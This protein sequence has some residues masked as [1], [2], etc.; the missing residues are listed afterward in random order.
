MQLPFP[1]K[2]LHG[3]GLRRSQFTRP[4]VRSVARTLCRKGVIPLDLLI[5]APLETTFRVTVQGVSFLY[6]LHFDDLFGSK[7]FWSGASGFEPDTVP[8]FIEH[9]KTAPRIIDVGA[10]TGFYTLLASAVNPTCKVMC[11]EPFAPTFQR[12]QQNIRRNKVE[13]R[14]RAV[15]AAVSNRE[16]EAELHGPDDKS[17]CALEEREGTIRVSALSLDS[18]VPMDGN[19]KLVKIDVEGHEH[20]VL[21]GMTGVVSDSRPAIFFECNP[22]G[23][24]AFIESF[25]RDHRYRMFSLLDRNVRELS[26]LVP[27]EMPHGHHNFL[28]LACEV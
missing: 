9:A 26:K 14:C 10:H 5:G 18:V 17:M 27:E 15:E 25:L 13:G 1:F 19:T 8:L 2:V 21:E 3:A 4:V 12:L 24:A 20:R 7:L 16:F 11:F 6:E 28:A 22:G 23:P